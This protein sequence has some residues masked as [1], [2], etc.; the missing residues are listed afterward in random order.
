MA[1]DEQARAKRGVAL[2]SI[3]VNVFL[4]ALKA[5]VGF[6][7]GSIA[8][9]AS[10]ADSLLDLTA[11]SFAYVGVR[12]GSRPPDDT[13]PYGHAKFESLS[14]LVQLGLLFVTVG[15]VAWEAV[16]RI[17][18]T[19]VVE[20]PLYGV[21]V[22]GVAL[23]VD[24]WISRRLHRVAEESGG[25]QALEADALHFAADV[26]SNIAVIIGLLAVRGGFE[27]GDPIA[28]L[29]VA[30]VV[31]VTAVGL[32]RATAVVLTDGAPDEEV[33]ATINTVLDDFP[34]IESHHTLRARLIG[35]R[36]FLDV[37]VELDPDLSFQRAHD[38]SH[39]L[40]DAL[41]RAVPEIED[42]VI[43]YEPVGHP[44]HQDRDH[45]SHGF[46]VL[47]PGPETP[48]TEQHPTDHPST[49]RPGGT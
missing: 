49:T 46:D 7:T 37:C 36:I 9:F 47:S 25:S 48:T 6:L 23:V 19:D 11:S 30:G 17:G 45:H 14:S 3:G 26:W 13:H 29:V 8:L 38:L 42:T 33:V 41:R 20:T 24:L 34:D 12:V 32:L 39:E 18:A 2:L 10:A 21:A 5:V 16:G 43:H 40:A 28:A 4:L 1:T 27:L 15:I 31:A 22:I 35:S 44:E